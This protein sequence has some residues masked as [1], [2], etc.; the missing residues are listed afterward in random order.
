M[1][2]LVRFL[3]AKV[4]FISFHDALQEAVTVVIVLVVSAG[5]TELLN[6]RPFVQRLSSR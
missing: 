2:V 3:P 6:D 1:F 4:G 5:F